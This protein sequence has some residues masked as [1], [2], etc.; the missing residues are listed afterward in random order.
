MAISEKLQQFLADSGVDYDLVPHERT[1]TSA[2]IAE[3]SHV[4]GDRLAKGVV[5]KDEEGYVLVVLPASHQVELDA[6]VD[7]LLR[8]L[9]I[10]PT[11]DVE[12]LF[13]DCDRGAVP[14]VGRAYG[15]DVL[16][17]DSLAAQPDIYFEGGDHASVVHVDRSGFDQL[18]QGA[19]HGRFSRHA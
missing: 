5:L 19:R 17:D 2:R 3:T 10:A 11:R 8:P 4:P 6:V 16:V 15:L 13:P 12:R 14:P 18:M 9:D 7:Q 1:M